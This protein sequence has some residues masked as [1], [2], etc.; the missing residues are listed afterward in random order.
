[1][2]VL[3]DLVQSYGLTMDEFTD[4]LRDELTAR[5]HGDPRALTAGERDVLTSIGVPAGDLDKPL[6]TRAAAKAAADLLDQAARMVT[7]TEMAQM[8]GRSESRIRGAIA[9]G[10]LLGVRIGRSW[11][12][13]TWQVADGHP[14]PHLRKVIA[15][16]PTGVG[17]AT[18]ERAITT[19][20]DELHLDGQA[21]SPRNWLLSGGDPEMVTAILTALYAW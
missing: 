8:L 3:T 19:P 17:L 6:P 18:I 4:E 2:T 5:S 13:P 20:T 1:M 15:A 11:R 12:L 21:V 16:R 7:T 14:I 9:D 10:S